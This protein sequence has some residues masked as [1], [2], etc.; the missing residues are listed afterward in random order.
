MQ[1]FKKVENQR[2][3]AG[4]R[5]STEE[6][7]LDRQIREW[8]PTPDSDPYQAG[9]LALT[10][11]LAPVLKGVRLLVAYNEFCAP[12]LPQ[13]VEKLIAEGV[14]AITVVPTMMTPGGSHSEVEIP[15]IMDSL[16]ARHPEIHLN[17]AWPFD[18]DKLSEMLVAHLNQF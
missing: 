4:Q 17:Y 15:E 1:K 13:A 9:L 14:N 2:R 7:E 6:I 16:R 12:D 5:P 18:L 10:G 3:A 8:T 11:K